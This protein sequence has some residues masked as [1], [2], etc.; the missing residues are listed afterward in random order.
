MICT[1]GSPRKLIH[2]SHPFEKRKI[3]QNLLY[4]RYKKEQSCTVVS[5]FILKKGITQHFAF[6]SVTQQVTMKGLVNFVDA[7]MPLKSAKS[8]NKIT[9]KSL[10]TTCMMR[11]IG[12]GV[13]HCALVMLSKYAACVMADIEH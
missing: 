13:L 3:L 5:S 6:I 12:M 1:I 2:H 8:L 11:Q 10:A 7:P 4:L 9:C